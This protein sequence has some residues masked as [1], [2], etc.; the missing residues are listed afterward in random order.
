MS[1]YGISLN[2]R[3]PGDCS[4]VSG[5]ISSAWHHP[6]RS[7]S[8]PTPRAKSRSMRSYLPTLRS[9]MSSL[10][11]VLV[12]LKIYLC[13]YTHTH[14]YFTH[15]TYTHTADTPSLAAHR[16]TRRSRSRDVVFAPLMF[17]NDIA[18]SFTFS[19]LVSFLFLSSVV[20]NQRGTRT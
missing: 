3:G 5:R 8:A 16:G 15:T 13:T 1:V 14:F 20:H 19:M 11:P 18:T 10:R 9:S 17:N 4:K 2:M 12:R 6:E 7:T